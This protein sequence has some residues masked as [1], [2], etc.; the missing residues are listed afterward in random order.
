MEDKIRTKLPV[1]TLS[2]EL[3]EMINTIQFDPGSYMIIITYSH[4]LDEKILRFLLTKRK[5]E[6][7][8]LKYLGMIGSKRKVKEVF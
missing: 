4:D 8:K 7:L 1:K 2:G 3:P 5:S 6:I